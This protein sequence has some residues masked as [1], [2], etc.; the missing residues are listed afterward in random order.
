MLKYIISC[1]FL[2]ITVIVIGQEAE[3]Q[4]KVE[5]DEIITKTD[6]ITGP[7]PFKKKYGLRVGIDISKPILSLVKDNYNGFEIIGDY[8]IKRDFYLA[9]EIGVSEQDTRRDTYQFTTKGSYL[10]AGF[11]YN[12]FRNWLEMDN[13]IY[14]GM[15]YGLSTFS[16]T[17]NHYT[18]F[19][20]GTE[21]NS[22]SGVYFEPKRVETPTEHNDLSAHWVAFIFGMKVETF[23]NLY[24]G[25]SIQF[26]QMLSSIQPVNFENLSVPG[27]NKVFSTSTGIGFNYTVSYR[28]PLYKK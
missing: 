10:S 3:S 26:N 11:N 21:V 28:I 25:A 2:F 22:V 4:K 16:Q 7:I 12:F 13:E 6:S 17:V 8:R 9:A 1:C 27:F 20:K 14:L 19:Q 23:K 18:V 24:L 15:R 5:V